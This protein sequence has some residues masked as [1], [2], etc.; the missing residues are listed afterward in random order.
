MADGCCDTP[1]LRATD[2]AALLR[3]RRAGEGEGEDDDEEEDEETAAA[4]L[5]ADRGPGGADVRAAAAVDG[6]VD[7]RVLVDR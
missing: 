5:P 6:A 2:G 7:G 1:L 4:R 3:R